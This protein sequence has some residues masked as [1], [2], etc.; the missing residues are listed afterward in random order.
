MFID[1]TPEGQKT[2]RLPF[3]PGRVRLDES[4]GIEF[5]YSKLCGEKRSYQQFIEDV[6][7]GSAVARRVLLH[8][9]LRKQH[10]TIR[11]EDVNPYED[12]IA[13]LFHKAELEEIR[14]A[15]EKTTAMPAN[16]KEQVLARLDDEIATAPD[17]REPGKADGTSTSEPDPSPTSGTST[18]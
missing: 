2:Q 11:I 18:S 17:A 8:H 3:Q 7:Q 10:P 1:Y 5:R 12:E 6:K 13:I 14:A 16:E 9:V 4:A 15:V